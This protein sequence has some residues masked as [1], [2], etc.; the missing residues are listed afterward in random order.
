MGWWDNIRK[1]LQGVTVHEI[2]LEDMAV[3]MATDLT[4]TQQE[5]YDAVRRAP[6]ATAR[7]LGMS[8]F[9]EDWR[10]PGRRLKELIDK[11]LVELGDKRRNEDTKIEVLTYY[12][13]D[14][15]GVDTIQKRVYDTPG[16]VGTNFNFVTSQP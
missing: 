4:P 15:F 10:I 11:G 16:V 6:G 7:E 13:V 14:A 3:D 1:R 9:P 8:Y 12:P 2:P 5:V